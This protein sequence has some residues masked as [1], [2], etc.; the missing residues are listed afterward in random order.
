[1]RHWALADVASSWAK[2]VAMKAEATRRPLFPAW[3][4]ALRRKWTRQRRRVNA[5]PWRRRPSGPLVRVG[6]RQLDA[7]QAAAPQLARGD[8]VPKVS[9]SEGPISTPIVYVVNI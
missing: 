6:D 7:A 2:A 5:A 9:A 8:S 3:A 4:S 1:L